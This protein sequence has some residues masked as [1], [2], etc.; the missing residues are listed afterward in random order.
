MSGFIILLLVISVVNEFFEAVGQVIRVSTQRPYIQTHGY[1]LLGDVAVD[2]QVMHALVDTGIAALYFTGKDWYE[3]FTHPGACITLPTGCYQCP[4]GCAVGPLTPII[5]TDGT[6]VD[7]FSHLGQL[8]FALGTVNSIQFGVVAGQQPGPDILVPTN[9]IGLGLRAILG[10]RSLMTQLQGKIQG[11]TFAMYLR[12]SAGTFKGELLLGGG[13]PRVYVA[14]LHYVPLLSQQEYLVTLDTLQVGGGPKR[15][16][17][18]KPILI[19]SGGQ[20]LII[21]QS[22]AG[23]FIRDISDRVSEAAGTRVQITWIP[24]LGI[25]EFGCSYISYFPMLLFGLGHGGS[26]LL[27][28]AGKYY[29]RNFGGICSLAIGQNPGDSWVLPDFLVIDRYVEFQPSQGRVGFANLI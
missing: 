12:D 24:T 18:N 4:G 2:G 17:M 16:G 21:P 6:K 29:T 22:F 3:H 13:D 11:Q 1:A 5:Y 25:W 7:I 14:P 26:V 10:Y 8:A 23:G 9:A 19:D 27:T 28:V 20:G 15:T